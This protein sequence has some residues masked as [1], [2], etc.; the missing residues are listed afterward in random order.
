MLIAG[1][2]GPGDLSRSFLN[3]EGGG[4]GGRRRRVSWYGMQLRTG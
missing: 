1:D 3:A 2:I 4:E